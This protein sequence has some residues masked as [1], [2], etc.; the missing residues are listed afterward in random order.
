MKAKTNHRR[1]QLANAHWQ[2]WL[3]A[4]YNEQAVEWKNYQQREVFWKEY[5]ALVAEAKASLGDFKISRAAAIHPAVPPL[6]TQTPASAPVKLSFTGNFSH[7]V[8]LPV[9]ARVLKFD[10]FLDGYRTRN[11]TLFFWGLVAYAIGIIVFGGNIENGS[12]FLWYLLGWGGLAGTSYYL[13]LEDLQAV[14]EL[15]SQKITKTSILG[16][17]IVHNDEIKKMEVIDGNLVLYVQGSTSE[18]NDLNSALF[19]PKDI[20]HRDEI[21]QYLEALVIKNNRVVAAKP[22]GKIIKSRI[23]KN[24]QKR[25]KQQHKQKIKMQKLATP[26]FKHQQQQQKNR[27]QHHQRMKG[28][29]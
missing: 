24:T 20:E 11:A 14:F 18:P 22:K 9:Q 7:A 16:N 15:N 8:Q 27:R 17:N 19:I 4:G 23:H 13:K 26:H 6:Q 3:D 1:E 10:D 28:R 29:K 5:E 2:Q 25:H 12:N 21:E